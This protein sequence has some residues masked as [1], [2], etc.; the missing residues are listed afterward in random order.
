MASTP[1]PNGRPRRQ[2]QIPKVL[3]GYRLIDK[4]GKG[5]SNSVFRARQVSMDREVAL[6]VLPPKKAQSDIIRARF[7]AE[8]H[9]TGRI[10]NTNVITCFDLGEDQ[11]WMY[12]ALELVQGGSLAD[13]LKHYGGVLPE[14]LAL[15]ITRDIGRGLEALARAGV[16]HR[17][18]KPA[19]IFVTG[20]MIPKI[21]DLGMA[22]ESAAAL[23]RQSLGF[24][25]DLII[26]TPNYMAP[27]QA[28]AKKLITPQ[29]DIF[30]LG[31]TLF[32]M[33]C[34]RPPYLGRDQQGVLALAKRGVIPDPRAFAPECS[35]KAVDVI[36]RAAAARLADRYPTA[37]EIVGVIEEALQG[38][39]GRETQPHLATELQAEREA[40]ERA[41]TWRK[42]TTEQ[43]EAASPDYDQFDDETPSAVMIG[44][45]Y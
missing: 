2:T 7:V 38:N 20:D 21:A 26:G 10:H 19:N 18:I 37:G 39:L 5:G 42:A 43:A 17:D 34:G 16:V 3:G 45:A 28:Q 27:E 31:G 6:K 8:A 35:T 40:R 41:R 25:D 4:L 32:R 29:A 36:R 11:G 15:G 12:M 44:G 14:R 22:V 33:L 13:L 1:E 9:L 23:Q 30:A 24:G